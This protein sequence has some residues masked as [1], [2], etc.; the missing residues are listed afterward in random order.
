MNKYRIKGFYKSLTNTDIIRID[1]TIEG[2]SP[3]DALATLNNQ[4]SLHNS[5]LFEFK[6]ESIHY[7]NNFK[8]NEIK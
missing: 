2:L 4:I 6:F 8:N 1:A 5:T 3:Q 7:V